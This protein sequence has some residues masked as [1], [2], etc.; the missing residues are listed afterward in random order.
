MLNREFLYKNSY[1]LIR[2]SNLKK[3]ICTTENS[4]YNTKNIKKIHLEFQILAIF[5]Q[6]L[7]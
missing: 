1:I 6:N 4:V 5:F 3:A 7:S 2:K